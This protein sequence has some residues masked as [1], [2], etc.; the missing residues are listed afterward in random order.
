MMDKER[1]SD[2]EQEGFWFEMQ[3]LAAA[4]TELTHKYGLEDKII[5]SFVVGLLEPFDEDTSNM[6]A[7]FH[8]N[9][10]SKSELEIIQEFMT[11]SYSPPEDAG[12][13]LDDLLDG[14][15]ISLN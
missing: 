2:M 7:F 1:Y 13:N 14:L 11:D 4:L 15:G 8:Y 5:S 10:Q 3:E 6:K 12:P 9:I